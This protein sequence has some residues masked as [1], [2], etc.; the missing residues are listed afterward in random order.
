M[1]VRCMYILVSFF[2]EISMRDLLENILL[3]VKIS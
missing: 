3:T 1:F 2:N